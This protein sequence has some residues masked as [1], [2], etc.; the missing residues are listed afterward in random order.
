MG[1]Q[2]I[3]ASRP[4]CAVP[5]KMCRKRGVIK[6]HHP[7]FLTSTRPKYPDKAQNIHLEIKG[8]GGEAGAKKPFGVQRLLRWLPPEGL[9]ANKRFWLLGRKECLPDCLAACNA[10]NYPSGGRGWCGNSIQ[11]SHDQ[12]KKKKKRLSCK[13][14]AKQHANKWNG[15]SLGLIA[16]AGGKN[17]S[18]PCIPGP[19]VWIY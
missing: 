15:L 5:Q 8:S 19:R 6:I 18:T 17:M 11:M 1:R 16:K 4:L 7:W 14:E 12:K 2:S 10:G 9:K 3:W 13:D